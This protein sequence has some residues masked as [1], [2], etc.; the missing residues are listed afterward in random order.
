MLLK[1]VKR[2]VLEEELLRHMCQSLVG[3]NRT[4]FD[5][6]FGA[7]HT[8]AQRL[9]FASKLQIKSPEH[10]FNREEPSPLRQIYWSFRQ[11]KGQD[12]DGCR[13]EL[14]VQYKGIEC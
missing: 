5:H 2:I 13:W 7:A 1:A 11:S 14:E 9:C 8:C 6:L 4:A 3:S 12:C 10:G